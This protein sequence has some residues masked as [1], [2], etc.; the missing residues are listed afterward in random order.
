MS[1]IIVQGVSGA[2]IESND[3]S[4][5]GYWTRLAQYGAAGYI[6]VGNSTSNLYINGNG[7]NC[8][9]IIKSDTLDA[10]SVNGSTGVTTFGADILPSASGTLDIGS[11]AVRFAEVHA[12][13]VYC[14]DCHVA[15]SSLHIGQATIEAS[16]SFLMSQ[17]FVIENRDSDPTSPA[18]GQMWFRTDL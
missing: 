4:S 11:A 15:E 1:S 2:E 5:S 9:T 13:T 10:I 14:D 8:N 18:I 7:E 16:G 12:D 6:N 3:S 17:S